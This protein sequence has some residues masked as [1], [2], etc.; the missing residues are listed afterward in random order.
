MSRQI[1][2][3]KSITPYK[4][5]IASQIVSCKVCRSNNESQP[6]ESYIA[7]CNP[8]IRPQN[9][10]TD[11]KLA[12]LFIASLV[13]LSVNALAHDHGANPD[14]KVFII[15]PKNGDTVS[16]PVTVKFGLEG[17][18]V[19]P[20]G[21]GPANSGHHHLIVDGDLP[22]LDKPMGGEVKHFGKGQTE[23]SLE[24]AP[25]K[26]TLQLIMGDKTHT[27]HKKPIYSEQITITVK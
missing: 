1:P 20:A 26:H 6:E 10:G 12:K 15:T 19:S 8:S 16:S 5:P 22:A 11:M 9:K 13:A 18:K 17:M 3:F 21:T 24:L 2:S 27:P 4:L 14:A 23:T 7:K 25:G